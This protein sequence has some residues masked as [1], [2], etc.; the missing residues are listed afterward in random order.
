M[1]I[2]KH[3]TTDRLANQIS[4]NSSYDGL[5]ILLEGV[6]DINVFSKH[7]NK[8][9]VKF[10]ICDGKYNQREVWEKLEQRNEARKL[11]IRD[12]DFIRLRGR[13]DK[14]YHD[15]FF[16][17]DHHDSEI[18]MANSGMLEQ[19]L[20]QA[21]SI[22]QMNKINISHPELLNEIKQLIYPLGCLKLANKIDNLGLVFKQKKEKSKE[23]D[24]TKFID[25]KTMTNK[26]V[27]SLITTCISYSNNLVAKGS[28]K[29]QDEIKNSYDRVLSCNHPIDEIVHGHDFSYALAQFVK[30]KLNQNNSQLK[31]GNE[32]ETF[33]AACFDSK[34]FRKTNLFN[35]LANWES[36]KSRSILDI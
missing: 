23:L 22:E 13:L 32:T 33:M 35:D 24:L 1:D 9:A 21:L 5:F 27:I 14:S 20:R 26:D 3:I 6:K 15:S 10:V 34:F 18:M 16:I 31:N 8:E 36:N 17:T 29:T 12:A 25:F 30:K 4:Q 28:I 11:A 2:I 7:F 19:C